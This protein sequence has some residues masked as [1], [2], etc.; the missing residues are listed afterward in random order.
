MHMGSCEFQKGSVVG[1]QIIGHW[2]P[3]LLFPPALFLNTDVFDQHYKVIFNFR[4][5]I[6]KNYSFAFSNT[7]FEIL[8]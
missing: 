1:T 7:S 8:I 5:Y 3:L 6:L 4:D 2:L